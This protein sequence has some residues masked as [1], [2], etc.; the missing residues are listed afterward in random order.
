M[1]NPR[2]QECRVYDHSHGTK[3]V[4]MRRGG[5]KKRRDANEPAIIQALRAIGAEVTQLSDAGAPDLLVKF[6]NVLYGWEIKTATG[7]RTKAQAVSRWPVIRSFTEALAILQHG[8][9]P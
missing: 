7:Q 6:R 4:E 1:N 2:Y 8:E 5:A 3:R 9:T